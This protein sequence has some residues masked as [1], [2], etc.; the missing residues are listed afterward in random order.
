MKMKK[1][2]AVL[3][4]TAMCIGVLAGCG[5][6]SEDNKS[7]DSS[8][9]AASAV[10]ESGGETAK[11]D[12][13]VEEADGDPVNLR[14]MVFGSTEVYEDI[15]REFFEINEDLAGKVNI[16]VELGGSGDFDVAEKIRLALASGEE[17]PDIIRL[18]YTQLPEFAE[19]GI[20]EP[21]DRFVEPYNDNIIEGAKVIMEY[22]GTM[23]AF[24]RE[25]KPKIWYYR[26][27][28]FEECG[29][30]PAEVKT[31]DDFIAAGEKIQEKYPNSHLENYNVPFQQYD[32]MMFLCATG[33]RFCDEE[34]N[35]DISADEGT[36]K[37]FEMIGK[38]HDSSV[39]ST[40]AEWSADWGP[41]FASDELISQLIAGWWRQDMK[42]WDIEELSGKIGLALWPEEIRYGSDA[43]GAIWVIPSSSKNKELAGD[44]LA[45]MCFDEETARMI[46]Q[47]AKI[48]PALKSA[49]DDPVYNAQDDYFVGNIAAVNFEAMEYL[50]VYPYTPA[51]SQ[52]I[53]IVKQYLDEYLSGSMT[54]EEALKAAEDDLKNQI[55]NPYQQ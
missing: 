7:P 29:I 47:K 11:T 53:T 54:V 28:I 15:N 32:L 24:P 38:I 25:I 41:A 33:G 17:L 16:E 18:N 39:N 9:G 23:Y 52:E 6:S 4:T 10:E 21:I 36:K 34:G 40:V 31:V 8:G 46:Y 14:M 48:L 51:S 13:A 19:A 35:Y 45:R 3:L 27:D 22:N 42:N 26:T 12:S 55:G 43:G 1:V 49:M 30:D 44:I 20:L 2:L 5:A 50:K 37:A